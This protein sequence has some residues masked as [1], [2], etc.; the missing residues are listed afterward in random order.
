M[1][2]CERCIPE[3][4]IGPPYC[5]PC[6]EVLGEWVPWEGHRGLVVELEHLRA[7]Y[8]EARHL[9]AGAH[10]K[11]IIYHTRLSELIELLSVD[12]PVDP[13]NGAALDVAA[14]LQDIILEANPEEK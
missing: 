9:Y 10:R 5:G 7:S 1:R 11:N 8:Y 4:F 12:I 3:D 6:S 14:Q 13:A 2:E